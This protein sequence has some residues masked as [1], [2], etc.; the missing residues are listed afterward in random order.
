MLPHPQHSESEIKKMVDW[1]FALSAS[2]AQSV[3]T[4]KV[5][6]LRV[7]KTGRQGSRLVLSAYHTDKG[8]PPMLPLTGSAVIRLRPRQVEAESS[9][10]RV[11][12]TVMSTDDGGKGQ[13]MLGSIAS[14]ASIRFSNMDLS[15]IGKIKCR[16]A[17]A[18]SGG[19]IEFRSDSPTGSLLGKA[20][21]KPTGGWGKYVDVVADIKPPAKAFDL[22]LVFR[23][24]RGGG[25]LMNLNWITCL[26]MGSSC[27]Y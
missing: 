21:V 16:V 11:K 9:D 24:P 13:Q 4:G 14:G 22:Y 20:E 26:M 2:G 27:L 5:I 6:K 25:G 15:G 12:L 8:A 18:G 10:K 3:D 1:V 19:F 7:P 23:H 17:S